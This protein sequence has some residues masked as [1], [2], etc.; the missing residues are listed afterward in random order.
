MQAAP[1]AEAD[2]LGNQHR[3][4]APE[5]RGL[6]LDSADAPSDHA[7]PVDHRGMRVGAEHAIGIGLAVLRGENH[8]REVFEIHLMHDAGV[9]RHHAEIIERALAPAQ[10]QVALLVALELELRVVRERRRLP[11]R[12]DLHRMIDHEIGGLQRIDPGG[13][14]AELA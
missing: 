14:A 5:H 11:E 6:G 2:H 1:E 9:G 10:E 3:D 13:V 7:Q 12:I 4:R 8:R